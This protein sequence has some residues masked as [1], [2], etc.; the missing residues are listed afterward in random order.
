MSGSVNNLIALQAGQGVTP[1][2]NPLAMQAQYMQA[3]QAMLQ[4]QNAMNQNLLFNSQRTQGR[5]AQQA[6][7]PTTSQFSQGTFNKL[8]GSTPGAAIGAQDAI[9]AAQTQSQAQQTQAQG[10]QKQLASGIGGLLQLNNGAGPTYGQ[11]TDFLQRGLA[12]GAIQPQSAKSALI[13]MPSGDDPQSMATRTHMIQTIQQ[14]MASSQ[15]QLTNAYG[16]PTSVNNGQ[17]AQPGMVGGMLSGNRGAFNPAGAPIQQVTGPET[18]A[19]MSTQYVPDPQ[20][21]GQYIQVPVPRS[22]MPGASGIAGPQSSASMGMGTGRPQ[23]PAGASPLGVASAS[24]AGGAAVPGGPNAVPP[25]PY[26][27]APPPGVAVS[28]Q[29]DT[30]Q[31]K[32]DQAALPAAQTTTQNMQ[33]A[34]TAL[35]LSSS[36]RTPQAMVGMGNLLQSAGLLPAG[37]T[38]D[39]ANYELFHK[40]TERLAMNAAGSSNTDAGRA[41][42]QASNAGTSLSTP[43]NIAVLQNDIGKQRQAIA[44]NLTAPDQQ[45]GIGYGGYAGKFSNSTDPRGFQW[46]M[47]QPAQKQQIL[48]GMKP[49]SAPW[50]NLHRSIGMATK[51]GL[52]DNGGSVPLGTPGGN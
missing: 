37:M 26:L 3:R 20:H 36:G 43:A 13:G 44:Q 22:S 10:S 16:T 46:D 50:N 9:A 27:A 30:A 51:L 39:L 14:Q 45:T 7:D 6:I 31:F 1:V 25:A 4:S 2:E 5:L 41:L 48:S 23:P 15:E 49:G 21:P 40:L 28:Q 35:Q 11:T 34:L 52:F 8:L 47:L 29:A 24:P 32:T 33:H 19:A 17:T 12:S 18:N 42:S 38:N